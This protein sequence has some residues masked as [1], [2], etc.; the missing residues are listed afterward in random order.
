MTGRVV[1][2]LLTSLA[3]AACGS[4]QGAGTLVPTSSSGAAPDPGVS[5]SAPAGLVAQAD[6]APCPASDPSVPAR[7][8][9]LPDLV[10]PCLGEGPDVRLAGLRGTPLVLN[11]WASWC[12]PCR[13][14]LPLLAH[15]DATTPGVELL[16]V[17]VEDRPDRALSLLVDTGVHY[18]SVRDTGRT[19]QPSLRWVGLPMT[20]FATAEGV[21][22]HVERAPITSQEQLD[23]LVSRYLGVS[24]GS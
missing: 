9:G 1:A 8:D 18:P 13:A 4:A 5:A 15:L 2:L 11:L 24:A 22:T 19:T 14:E 6:L 20:V 10:L 12:Q 21:V 23:G 7:S 17:D 3:L 16:G